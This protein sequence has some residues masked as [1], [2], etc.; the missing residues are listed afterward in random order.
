MISLT[1]LLKKA[2]KTTDP[3]KLKTY[4]NES[5][6]FDYEQYKAIQTA[7]NKAKITQSWVTESEIVFIADIIRQYCPTPSFGIC[8]GTRQGLEQKWFKKNLGCR[9]VIGTEISD[10]A[11]QFPDTVQWDFHEQNPD[12]INRADFVY[13]N[14]FD[15]SYDPKKAL[16]TW[17][18]TLTQSGVCIIE[19]SE[20]HTPENV[21]R[22][23]PF[24]I[25]LDYFPYQ[26]LEWS[27]G[28]YSVRNII[29]SPIKKG[30]INAVNFV[31]IQNN[32]TG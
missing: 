26:V 20:N 22:L 29:Q 6:T 21:S 10:T 18:Q 16:D 7:G 24:G 2:T 3:V 17:M 12:W 8:H 23:D 4:T 15:H 25:K 19:H 14:S 30:D 31:V 9:E 13:S 28:A 1:S 11:T 27:N 32:I 5:G